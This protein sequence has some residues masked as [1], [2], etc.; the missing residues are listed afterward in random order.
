MKKSN[1]IDRRSMLK[2]SAAA[3]SVLALNG[4]LPHVDISKPNSIVEENRKTGTSKWILKKEEILFDKYTVDNLWMGPIRSSVVE[5]YCDKLYVK[6]GEEISFHVSAARSST[7]TLSIYRIGYYQG[8]GGRLIRSAGPLQ[9]KNMGTPDFSRENFLIECDWEKAYSVKITDEWISGFY[10]VKLVTREGWANYMSFVVVDEAPRD[11]VLQVSDFNSHAY[12]RWPEHHSLYNN[13]ETGIDN[14]WG[15]RNVSSFRRPQ[16]KLS[17]LVDLPLTLGAGEF[18]AWQY[19]FVFW[20]EKNGYDITYISNMTLHEKGPEV[21][22]RASGFLSVGH[23]EYWTD[24]MYRNAMAARDQGVSMGFFCGNSVYGRFQLDADGK[25]IQNVR[26]RRNGKLKDKDLMGS[27]SG[28]DSGIGGGNWKVKDAGHWAFRGTGMKDGDAIEAL[29]GWEYHYDTAD[30]IPG[31]KKL[32]SDTTNFY[33]WPIWENRK[34]KDT[35]G[36]F[37]A[38]YYE[39]EGKRNFVFNAATCWWVYGFDE[40]PAWKRSTWYDGRQTAD[41][42]VMQITRNVLDEMI[43]RGKKDRSA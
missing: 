18:F 35:H 26:F 6:P 27:G 39:P 34:K 36:E 12:N 29:V 11:L 40:P 32:A 2:S 9:G 30:D 3:L 7:Y 37:V 1:E 42:R 21:L 20:A 33:E 38:T 13:I 25:G 5:G 4:R 17:Q 16:A 19:P 23:D 24:D 14:Y 28:E 22:T 15:P 31:L 10:V 8:H 43:R 41:P